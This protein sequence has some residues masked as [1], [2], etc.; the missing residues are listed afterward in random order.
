MNNKLKELIEKKGNITDVASILGITK[1]YL[2]M[3]INGKRTSVSPTLLIILSKVLDIPATEL[4]NIIRNDKPPDMSNNSQFQFYRY[5][6]IALNALDDNNI[7]LLDTIS[8]FI[9]DMQDDILLKDNFLVWHSALKKTFS[10][11]YREGLE[12]FLMA[13]EF[14]AKFAIEKRFKAKILAGIGGAYT[15]LGNYK[16]GLQAFRSCLKLWSEG[17][18]TG[19]VYLNLGT[20][21]RRKQYIDYSKE[22]YMK[23]YELG[24]DFVKLEA[25]SSLIQLYLDTKDLNKARYYM[26]NGYLAGKIYDS[27][28]GKADLFVNIGA[29]FNEDQKNKASPFLSK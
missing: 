29:Y 9:T 10:A 15:A 25:L 11:R 6:E 2:L 5:L 12:G 17:K 22:S 7:D 18:A 8:G 26:I 4:K 19:L 16:V 3:L 13:V 1:E 21:Y 24:A 20:V 23:A 28:R 14:T 27:A